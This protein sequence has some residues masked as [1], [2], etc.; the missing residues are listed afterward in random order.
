[1][2]DDIEL[3]ENALKILHIIVAEFKSDPISTQCFDKR[4]V[5]E[6]IEISE[7]YSQRQQKTTKRY[8]KVWQ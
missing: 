2:I 5:E 4:I 3:G 7:E 8:R 6:A 1:M